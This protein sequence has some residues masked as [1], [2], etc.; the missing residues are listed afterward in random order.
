MSCA[1]IASAEP[2]PSRDNVIAEM[3]PYNGPSQQGVDCSTLDRKT[4]CGY[5][6]WFSCPGDGADLGWKHYGRQGRFDPGTCCFDLWPDTSELADEEKFATPFRHRDG[7]TAYVFSSYREPTVLRHFRWMREY[8]IDGVFVQRFAVATVGG[9]ELRHVNTV[10]AHCREGANREGRAYALMYDLSGL[11][12]AK[13]DQVIDDWR[14]LVDRMRLGRD[15]ADKAYLQHRGRPVVAVWGIGFNDGRKYTLAECRRLVEFLRHDKTYGNNCVMLG[16]PTGWRTLDRDSMPEPALHEIIAAADIVSPWT[17]GRYGP[18]GIA[19]HAERHWQ[20]DIAWCR[21][22]GKDYVPVVFPGFSWHN[23]KPE[24]PSKQIPRL[25]GEFLWRQYAELRRAGATMAYL[26]MFDE[27]DEGTAIFKC[28]ND[29]P[30]GTSTF[31]TYEGLPSD[32]YLWMVGEAA[33]MIRGET[34]LRNTQPVR[35]TSSPSQ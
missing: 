9:R 23:L 11:G 6:G 12:E 10:L 15:P 21:E 31:I 33:K 20:P 2:P 19:R 3:R 35:N 14:L 5:Q 16:V 32:H 22:H 24:S 17:V 7:R 27:I 28:T 13:I 25:K 29:P 1:T 30:T 18:D 26:A 8:G 4:M 34:S